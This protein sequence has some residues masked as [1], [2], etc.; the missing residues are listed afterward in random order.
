MAELDG[1]VAVIT[2][3]SRGIGRACALKLAEHGAKIAFNYLTNEA[4]A[5]EVQDELKK[6]IEK[7]AKESSKK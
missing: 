2:G 1:K 4:K 6:A 3:A 5:K 7:K